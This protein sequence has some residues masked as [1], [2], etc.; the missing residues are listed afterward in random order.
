MKD[1][2]DNIKKVMIVFLLCFMGLISYI[3]Y[4]QIIVAPKIIS[5][6]YNQRLWA[7]RNEV[8][9][10]TIYDRNM[11]AL[12]KSIRINKDSQKRQYE[13]GA[14]S[15][16]A[17]GYLDVKYGITGL[18]KKY[19]EELTS[20]SIK[21]TISSF[22]KANDKEPE[23]YG[24]NIKTTLDYNVQKKA[25]E[26]LGD[27][28]GAVVALNPKTGEILAMVSKPSFNPND[29]EKDW[30]A[31]NTN[32]DRPLLNRATAGLYPPGSIFKTITAVSALDNIPGIINK[33]FEDNGVLAFNSKESLKNYNGEVLGNIG[34]KEAFVHS[35]NVVFGK[36]GIDIG[37]DKLKETAEKFY[38]NKDIPANGLVIENSRFPSLKSYEKGNLAQSAIG[39]A[40]VLSTPIEM[41]LTAGTI[42]NDGVM[43]KPYIVKEVLTS[44]REVIKTIK[45]ESLNTV[46]SKENAK[47]VKDFMRGV[48]SDGTGRGA[49]LEGIEVCGKTGTADYKEEGSGAS[50]HSWF[51]GFAPY[52]DPQI[53]LAVIVE[54]GGQGGIAAASIA[55][56]VFKAALVK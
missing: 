24:N 45:P 37:N 41:A 12:T 44:K 16:H 14:I 9:R 32:K 20:T 25:Y 51:I 22:I 4:F 40:T 50:P 49:A 5:S 2:S 1:I 19:D 47:I 39:Q 55:S 11:K 26:L 36:L 27:N 33:R 10:G 43:M 53:A 23:K 52:N 35:S 15:A 3:T 56:G 38:F 8:L 34:F 13:G 31:I 48:V 7:K 21:E 30:E 18:E 54:G 28:R 29:L 17:L 46:T 6:Q 42:A